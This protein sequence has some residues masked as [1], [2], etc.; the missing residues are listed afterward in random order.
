MTIR[1]SIVA[2][3]RAQKPS[4]GAPA[5]SRFINR[6]LGRVFAALA[7]SVRMTPN[8]VTGVSAVCTFAAIAIIALVPP[9]PW[10]ALTVVVLLVLGYALDSADGQLAR[11]R[12]G[13]SPRGEW[14]DH[15]VDATKMASI[16][17]AVLVCWSRFYSLDQA[18]LLIPL[19]FALV[20]TVFFFG[21]ILTDLIRRTAGTGSSSWSE[22]SQQVRTSPLFAI[23]VLPVDYGVLMLAFALL[24]LP[25]TF[26]IVYTLL[27]VANALILLASLVRWY[28]SLPG[29]GAHA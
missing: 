8:Q 16:H 27:L 3:Q 11:L 10:S 1:Q 24:W 23:A 7:H 4:S 26:M 14:L 2:L 28:R 9:E 5:Y 13:G 19:G 22:R 21:V 6:P 17:L 29:D 20:S 12:G 15:M 25:T 18:W